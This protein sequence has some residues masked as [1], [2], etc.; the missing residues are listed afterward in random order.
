MIIDLP[1]FIAAERPSWTELERLLERLEADPYRQMPLEEVQR[2]HFL[3]Q[4]VSADLGR[5]ATFASEPELKRYLESL[6]ARAYG[7]IHETRERGSRF[8]PVHWFLV[9]FPR[10]FRK[11]FGAFVVSLMITVAGML[12][13]GLS[14]ALDQD[15][16]D[17][18]LPGQFS[19]L[20]ND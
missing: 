6:T 10:V 16:K 1:R 3:Y 7:E 18:I 14:V 5:V 17:A 19:H 12:F 15:A 8:R 13:G 2:F 9:E 11:Q 20:L 4:K